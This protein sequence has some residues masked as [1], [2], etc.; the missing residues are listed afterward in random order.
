MNDSGESRK[1]TADRK[2]EVLSAKCKTRIGFWNVRTVYETGKLAQATAEM[3][4]YNLH[5]FGISESRW[6]GSGRH[7]ISTGETVLYS[8]REDD[9]HH[10]GEAIIL[11]KGLE[12]CLMEWKPINSRLLKVRL[13]GRHI[14]TTII[15]CYA[16]TNDSEEDN[17]DTFYEQ[18]QA[19]LEDA[20]RHE[21]KIMMGDLNAKVGNDNRNYERATGKEGCGTMNDNGERLLDIYTTHDFVIGTFFTHRDVHK[22]T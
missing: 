11:K 19:E 15:Q 16:P 5:V 12:K 14:N 6:T 22:L 2:M 21:M 3:R 20:P 13:K 9:Q 4:R 8:G 18:L 7:K 1:E 10:E 17:K